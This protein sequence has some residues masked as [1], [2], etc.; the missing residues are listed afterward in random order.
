[1]KRL[2]V[3][4]MAALVA[5]LVA[6][7]AVATAG[8]SLLH[9]ASL[10]GGD[11]GTGV[12]IDTMDPD[13]GGSPH[14]LG[15]VDTS[16]GVMFTSTEADGRSNALINWYIADPA[17]RLSFRNSGTVSFMFKAERETHVSGEIFGDNYGFGQFRN[18]Q[19]AISASAS[20]IANGPG[21][22]DDQVQVQWKTTDGS[23][24]WYTHG[25]VTL[26]YDRWYHIGLAWGS[27][28]NSH[29][30]WVCG[31]LGAADSVGPIP[32]GVSWG[33]GSATNVGLGCNHE[34][35]YGL[36]SSAAGVTFADV[37]IWDEYRPQGDTEPCAAPQP[38]SV[39]TFE[40]NGGSGSVGKWADFTTTYSDP[41]GYEDIQLA[42]FFLDRQPPI[43]SGGLA[44]VYIQP[45][46]ILWLMG[47]GFCRPGQPGVAET[48][49]VRIDCG[50]S[51]VS[52]KDDTLTINWRV[53]PRRC[54]DGDCGVNRAYEF[55]IDTARLWDFGAVGAWTLNPASGPAQYA[56]PAVQPTEADLERLREEIEA[57]QS[58]LGE[59][60]LIQR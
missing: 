15:I 24:P 21:T 19:S 20:R 60:Y 33:T 57:W 50:N 47:D 46:D 52:G 11:Y 17:D 5:A 38:P 48:D 28:E 27:S 10:K 54:F 29:E 31:Q 36:Y 45:W 1:M 53:L 16:E 25:P 6:G 55:V 43:A 32:W 26:E 59:S 14:A 12:A 41:N 9:E 44:A 51:S 56:G 40:P 3:I 18:G 4:A 37:R 35:G 42:F 30:T 13:H 58:Q 49:F 39:G 7:G 34:R 22:A 8:G 2:A 23:G